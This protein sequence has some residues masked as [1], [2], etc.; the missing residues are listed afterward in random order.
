MTTAREAREERRDRVLEAIGNMILPENIKKFFDLPHP[1]F[2]N[3]RPEDMLDSEAETQL[4][5]DNLEA[6]KS[7]SYM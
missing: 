3:R 1:L 7:G 5:I 4:L 2:N 6:L